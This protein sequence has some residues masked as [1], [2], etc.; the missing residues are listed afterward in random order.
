MTPVMKGAKG[1]NP[2]FQIF[3]KQQTYFPLFS[4]DHQG[5][6]DLGSSIV[7]FAMILFE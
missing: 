4:H 7:R 6:G 2:N 1:N 5:K 3:Q